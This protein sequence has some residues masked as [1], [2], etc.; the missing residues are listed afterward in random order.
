[1]FALIL[2]FSSGIHYGTL[3]DAVCGFSRSFLWSGVAVLTCETWVLYEQWTKGHFSMPYGQNL[4]I[5]RD[6]TDYELF[7][8]EIIL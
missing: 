7:R 3:L 4:S 8:S 6:V 1:M 5:G 2:H